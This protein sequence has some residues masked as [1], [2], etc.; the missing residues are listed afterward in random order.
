[1]TKDAFP[2]DAATSLRMAGIRRHGTTP[3]LLVRKRFWHEG[4]RFTTVNRDLPGSPDLAN[5]S[6]KWAVFVHGCFWHG[7]EGCPRATRPKRNA[8]AWA[9]KIAANRQRDQLK[10]AGLGRLGYTVVTIWEC[11]AAGFGPSDQRLN[12]IKALPPRRSKG[13]SPFPPA[14]PPT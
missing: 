13:S 12:K 4:M 2:T 8:G 3:E 9:D 11:E 14:H 5:R 1:V 10:E 6:R 7:H